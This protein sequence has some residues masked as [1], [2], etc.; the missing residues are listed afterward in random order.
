MPVLRSKCLVVNLLPQ[1][2]AF[3][4]TDTNVV[5]WVQV[6]GVGMNLTGSIGANTLLRTQ[7][8]GRS[9]YNFTNTREFKNVALGDRK[10]YH[11]SNMK[12][13]NNQRGELNVLLIPVILLALLFVGAA[14][15]A[16]WAYGSQQDYKNNSDEKAAAAVEANKKVIQS[17]DATKYAEAAKQPLKLYVGPDAFGSLKLN[18]PKTWSA[19]VIAVDASGGT[20]LDAYFNPDYVPGVGNQSSSFALR[21]KIL[22]QSY[23]SIVSQ[24]TSTVKQ[25]KATATPYKLPK[26]PSVIG[27][28]IEGQLAQNKQG[29]MVI[30]PLRDKTLEIWTESDTYKNDFNNNILANTTFSP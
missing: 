1:K 10:R 26:L 8:Y 14:S 4:Y 7:K 20:P 3:I 12:L 29:S 22:T 28:R 13:A 16:V 30:L 18:Y 17:A 2:T 21:V 23:S 9:N 5:R 19:Y 15:F 24:Y 11:K 25:G 6:P 27:T